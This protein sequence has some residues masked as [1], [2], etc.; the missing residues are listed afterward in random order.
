[1]KGIAPK[2]AVAV[3]GATFTFGAI[4]AKAAAPEY[5]GNLNIVVGS[6]IS[7]SDQGFYSMYYMRCKPCS[8]VT[9][10]TFETLKHNG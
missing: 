2:L 5:G 8:I 10:D 4:S 7:C 1:M 9:A 3:L 6:K